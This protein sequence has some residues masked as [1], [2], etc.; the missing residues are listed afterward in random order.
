MRAQIL[1]QSRVQ[2]FGPTSPKPFG[3]RS[4]QSTRRWKLFGATTAVVIP[5]ILSLAI[6]LV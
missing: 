4:S 3:W 2:D 5:A 6:G 1:A